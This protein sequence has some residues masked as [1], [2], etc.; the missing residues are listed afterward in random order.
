[1]KTEP[2]EHEYE[3]DVVYP[4]A[5]PFVL[6]HVACI[7]MLWTGF[8]P[9]AAGL[10]VGLYVVRMI[11]VTAGYHRYFSHRSYRTS[12]VGQF[13]LAFV[14]QST[15][16]RGIIW[17]AAK[18]RTHHKYSDTPLDPHSPL[19]RGFWFA[20]V[21]WIF[22]ERVRD[23]DY[24][25]VPD[26]TKY[27]ELLWLDRQK[28]LPAILLAVVVVL[29]AGWPGLFMGFFL[30]TVLLYHGTFAINSL[31]HLHGKQRYVT[32]DDSRNNWWLALIT[33]GEGWHNNHH[34]FQSSVRQGFYWWEIDITYYVVKLAS[35][36]GLVWDI[37]RPP[38]EVIA[39]ERRLGTV[40]I[41]KVARQLAES[42]PIERIAD[43]VREAIAHKVDFEDL[44]RRARDARSR[45]ESVLAE[46]Q[47]PHLPTVEELK[48]QAREMFADTPS[49]DDIAE[50][51]RKLIHQSVAARLLEEVLAP[52]T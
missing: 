14:C 23:A 36:F 1:M 3:H 46:L 4:E 40:V 31:A 45:A 42:F 10:C 2:I 35:Y 26:L 33:F 50:R 49:L 12:R 29:V 32:G 9:L 18:H 17:W 15:A 5:I 20:H 6:F 24:R 11:A 25:L 39:G 47:M 34:F 30:S 38:A 51:A 28:Y 16:Q 52:A 7:G 43:Q 37:R 19:Q 13:I 48:A 27:P 44:A 21:G 41:D 8:T 22:A